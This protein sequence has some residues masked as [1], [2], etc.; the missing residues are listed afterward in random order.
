MKTIIMHITLQHPLFKIDK[1]TVV[2]QKNINSIIY[3]II[4]E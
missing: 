2:V 1:N 3:Y 4:Q